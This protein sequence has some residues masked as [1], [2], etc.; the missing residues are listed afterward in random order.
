MAPPAAPARSVAAFTLLAATVLAALLCS[1]A[2]PAA[3][4]Q[5][6]NAC[7]CLK[8]Q[9]AGNC[10]GICACLIAQGQPVSGQEGCV[11][12]CQ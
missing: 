6:L 8:K 3:Q 2:L 4:A 11:A 10:P 7:E 5:S 12:V 1:A 9:T